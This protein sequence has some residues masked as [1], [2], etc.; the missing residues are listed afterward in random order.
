MLLMDGVGNVQE[1]MCFCFVGVM[2]LKLSS[3]RPIRRVFNIS[4]CPA[5]L[6]QSSFVSLI[7][8]LT[9]M[10]FC[11]LTGLF[12]LRHVLFILPGPQEDP[13][14]IHLPLLRAYSDFLSVSGLSPHH[15]SPTSWQGSS[16]PADP[17][18]CLLTV[19]FL[20]LFILCLV[21]GRRDT[22]T[23]SGPHHQSPLLPLPCGYTSIPA[24]TE[25][26]AES[27]PPP[28]CSY[29]TKPIK[30]EVIFFP[31]ISFPPLHS[32]SFPC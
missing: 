23:P 25:W 28:L 1:L 26:A 2:V 9:P 7:R 14:Q 6:L 16:P 5:C 22:H 31:F 27:P 15:F 11:L 17:L 3:Q 12:T 30:A 29:P 20:Y 21:P 19:F 24:L 8:T 4:D 10:P 18:L 13:Q 32:S